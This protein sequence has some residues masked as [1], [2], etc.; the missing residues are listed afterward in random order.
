MYI[1]MNKN[2]LTRK[3]CHKS[4]FDLYLLLRCGIIS[5]LPDCINSK[6][7]T[8]FPLSLL[9]I[10][11]VSDSD[12]TGHC[13]RC[14]HK[15]VKIVISRLTLNS[16]DTNNPPSC[17]ETVGISFEQLDSFENTILLKASMQSARLQKNVQL[18]LSLRS[19]YQSGFENQ[20]FF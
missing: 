8:Y 14:N 18:L 2:I 13:D 11:S 4:K 9:Q 19:H 7:Y 17:A 16:G 1:Y 15:N 20:K 6:T 10:R 12:T 5:M 3:S